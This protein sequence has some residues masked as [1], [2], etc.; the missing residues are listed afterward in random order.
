MVVSGERRLIGLSYTTTLNLNIF[1]KFT[2]II[3]VS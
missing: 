1:S 3:D 2:I